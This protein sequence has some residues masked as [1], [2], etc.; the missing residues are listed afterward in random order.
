ML[1]VGLQTN[2]SCHTNRPKKYPARTV[3]NWLAGALEWNP[4][5]PIVRYA[6]TIFLDGELQ[7]PSERLF[8]CMAVNALQYEPPLTFFNN[9]RTFAHGTH[10]VFNL[11]KTMSPIVDLVRMYA[12]KHRIFATNTGE[13]LAA[14]QALG[15]FTE[16]EAHELLQSYYYLMGVRLKKQAAQI[17][18]DNATPDNYLD[19]KT[20]TKVE[21]VT[22]KEIFKVIADFQLKIKVGFTKSLS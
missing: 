7:K 9:I 2:F 14:L 3:P 21:Q 13:R 10:Q 20:L 6:Q 4:M 22:L 11:K 16:R 19:P 18:N 8:R 1:I 5:W 17:I 15:I 12:L